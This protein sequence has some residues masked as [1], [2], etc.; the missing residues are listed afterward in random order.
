MSLTINL[1]KKDSNLKIYLR[2]QYNINS[3]FLAE[4]VISELSEQT[5]LIKIMKICPITDLDIENLLTKL[6]AKI[7]FSLI[8]VENSNKYY[9]FQTAL[10][11]QCFMNDYI[12]ET[13][14]NEIDTLKYLEEKVIKSLKNNKQPDPQKILCLASYKPLYKYKWSYLINVNDDIKEVLTRQILEPLN[15][16]DLIKEIPTLGNISNQ[17][18]SKV[19]KL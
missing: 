16:N 12:Y 7:L 9:K 3:N 1:L 4:E 17:V 5:S 13:S 18:S 14:Q 11:M 19:R 10:A 6:R 2:N 8:E 15:E